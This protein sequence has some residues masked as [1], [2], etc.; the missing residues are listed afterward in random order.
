MTADLSGLPGAA[1][2]GTL[3]GVVVLELAQSFAA[4]LAGGL[5]ADLGAMVIRSSPRRL[6]AGVAVGHRR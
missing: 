6:A 5:L 4:E 2:G 1:R 3:E